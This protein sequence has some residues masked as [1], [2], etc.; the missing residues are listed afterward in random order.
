MTELVE[1]VTQDRQRNRIADQSTRAGC[2]SGSIGGLSRI[3]RDDQCGGGHFGI[4]EIHDSSL[5]SK[6]GRGKTVS[7]SYQLLDTE[8][9][10]HVDVAAPLLP[11]LD[12]K[13]EVDLCFQFGF[14]VA[15]GAA[16][17]LGDLEAV[18]ADQNA[19]L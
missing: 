18:L 2:K 8:A 6:T 11:Y 10:Q 17:D 4:K 16:A 14:D 9:V 12:L 13:V 19:L 3:D 15:A 5:S 7:T 1:A